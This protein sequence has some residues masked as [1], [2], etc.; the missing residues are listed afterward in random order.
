[1]LYTDFSSDE[2]LHMTKRKRQ[3]GVDHTDAQLLKQLLES[4][5]LEAMDADMFNRS[6]TAPQ[7]Q[8]VV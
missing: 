8:V 7:S 3:D 5:L 6:Y 4:G 1:M 2:S